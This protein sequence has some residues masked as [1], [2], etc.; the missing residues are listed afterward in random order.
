MSPAALLTPPRLHSEAKQRRGY[1]F[2]PAWV[3]L[4]FFLEIFSQCSR[5]IGLKFGHDAWIDSEEDNREF[6]RDSFCSFLNK[7]QKPS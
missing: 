6:H 4:F 7:N 1:L 3:S 5:P 2:Y